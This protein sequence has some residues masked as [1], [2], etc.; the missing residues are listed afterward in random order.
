MVQ[1]SSAA[2]YRPKS[3]PKNWGKRR[4]KSMRRIRKGEKR[5]G[6]GIQENENAGVWDINRAVYRRNKE[7]TKTD[8]CQSRQKPLQVA[9]N[10]S[11][12]GR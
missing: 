11:I 7:I 6:I 5:N 4:M 3:K 12:C 9:R 8:W 2:V 1:R 10:T